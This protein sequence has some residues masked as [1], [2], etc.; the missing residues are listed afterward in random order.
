LQVR[1]SPADLARRQAEGLA[2]QVIAGTAAA[3]LAGEPA[4]DSSG[5]QLGLAGFFGGRVEEPAVLGESAAGRRDRQ[6]QAQQLGCGV[7]QY[8]ERG[9]QVRGQPGVGAGQ[10]FLDDLP[11]LPAPGIG[12]GDRCAAR[13][14]SATSSSSE[15]AIRRPCITADE[16]RSATR[17]LAR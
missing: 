4:A 11:P 2:A 7:A 1:P 12:R 9:R 6:V 13:W 16:R 5:Q 8:L 3:Q 15:R 10:S 17:L 14:V